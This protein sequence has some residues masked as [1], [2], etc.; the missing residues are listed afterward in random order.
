MIEIAGYKIL[1]TLGRGGMS[2]VH[3]AL[4]ESV[5]R[6]VALKVM[7]DTLRGDPEFGARFLREARIAARLKHPHVVQIHDVGISGDHHFIAM[8]YLPGGPALTRNGPP[9]EVGFALRLTRQI[10]TALGYAGARGVVH[11]D[12]KPD[13]ILL[14]EDGAAVLTD[15]GIARA[16]DNARMTRTGAIIGTP[17]Y[18]SP[19]QA[20][21]LPLDERA[22]L[23]S[24]GVV[25]YQLLAG[26]VP[27]HAEDSLAVGIMHITAPLPRLPERLSRLQPLLDRLLA[28][29]PAQR[30][31]TGFELAAALEELEWSSAGEEGTMILPRTPQPNLPFTPATVRRMPA[32]IPSPMP[33]AIPS[34]THGTPEGPRLGRMDGLSIEPSRSRA[35]ARSSRTGL[36]VGVAFAFVALLL[37]GAWLFQDRLRDLLPQTRMNTLL[38]QAAGALVEDRLIGDANSARELYNA[39]LA[40][41]PDSLAARQGLQQVGERLLRRARSELARGDA[42]AARAALHAARELSVPALAADAVR[43]DIERAEAA[44]IEI[45]DGLARAREALAQGRLDAE[46]DGAIA[47]FRQVLRADPG[48]A[49]AA[50]G[51]RDALSGLLAR[52]QAQAAAG[53]LGAAAQTI[54]QVESIDAAHLG[55]PEARTAVAQARERASQAQAQ[56]SAERIAQAEDAFKHRRYDGPAGAQ[57]LF[58]AVLAAEPA[59]DAA[60]NGLRRIAAAQLAQ[61][62]RHIDD[63]EFEQARVLIDEA[64]SADPDAPGLAATRAR[65]RDVERRRAGAVVEAPRPPSADPVRIA[66]LLSDASVAV[67]EGRFL[68]PPGD[69]AYDHYRAVLA[70]DPGNAAANAGLNGLPARI[71]QRFENQLAGNQLQGALGQINALAS[72]SVS[73]PS[74]PGMRKRLAGRF[75]AYAAERIGAGELQRA[76]R[77]IDN[78]AELDP[79]SAELPA[80]QAR[81][82]QARGR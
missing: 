67:A 29:D 71:R 66:K 53:D 33:P 11:R 2:T 36:W 30:F 50:S 46:G 73:D 47:L 56:Q 77:A 5:E 49:L 45:E 70:L 82:E 76:A 38:E 68:A 13:N 27:Y 7:A 78:A 64:A 10:A 19:E 75:L 41:D 79:T 8:E 6:E 37:G 55:L 52:A 39:A 1:K 74:L 24:L 20:R 62:Q 25:L 72:L 35:G 81:L 43:Q 54:A 9:R 16:S 61:A 44:S 40:Q 15:F 18:M 42:V 3:L 23:Y 22:D 4:Q 17:H 32:S 26:Q 80:M 14:R 31:Q 51:L 59:N 60:R 65:L 69:C 34:S 57:A 28:K 58:R 63:Y 48:N 12:I 21:G